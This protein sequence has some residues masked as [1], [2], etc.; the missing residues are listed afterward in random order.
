MGPALG[1]TQDRCE[2]L[3]E[4]LRQVDVPPFEKLRQGA[5]ALGD[6]DLLKALELG[7]SGDGR[8]AVGS[9][10]I[11]ACSLPQNLAHHKHHGL[12]IFVR[13]VW[14]QRSH[15]VSKHFVL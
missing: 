15:S 2:E 8:D 14:I 1:Q 6:A 4:Q 12:G 5:M 13:T 11:C 7:T 10:F 9:A 3:A